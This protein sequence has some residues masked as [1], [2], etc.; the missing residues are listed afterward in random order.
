MEDDDDGTIS[1]HCSET[2]QILNSKNFVSKKMKRLD[3]AAR[4]DI[5]SKTF[6][7]EKKESNI[8][9][10]RMK[11]DGPYLELIDHCWAG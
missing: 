11:N 9:Y 10:W 3:M 6:E 8:V 1:R 4:E 7:E 2:D 5:L